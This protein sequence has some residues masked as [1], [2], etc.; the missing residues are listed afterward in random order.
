MMTAT[1]CFTDGCLRK[2]FG[3]DGEIDHI[4]HLDGVGP[5]DYRSVIGFFARQLL[6]EM[7]LVGG[8]DVMYGKVKTFVRDH[9]FANAVDLE[10]AVVLRN[11]S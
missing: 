7:K 11:L 3:I 4:T 8:Y 6:K 5:A 9:L 1:G 10:A 2:F